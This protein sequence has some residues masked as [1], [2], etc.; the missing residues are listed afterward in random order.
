MAATVG[1]GVKIH[2]V[3]IGGFPHNEKFRGG[4]HGRDLWW[5]ERI[6]L[7]CQDCLG[8]LSTQKGRFF[9]RQIFYSL[10]ISPIR[11]WWITW[12]LCLTTSYTRFAR[13]IGSP[14]GF[15]SQTSRLKRAQPASWSNAGCINV[16]PT[17]ACAVVMTRQ[18]ESSA[19]EAGNNAAVSAWSRLVPT[20]RVHWCVSWTRQATTV[21]EDHGLLSPTHAG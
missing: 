16:N 1:I 18:T 11:L 8:L 21:T 10:L 5:T 9:A 3:K 20:R 4:I 12:F 15:G 17:I 2:Y 7:R 13:S 6:V 19:L 14:T